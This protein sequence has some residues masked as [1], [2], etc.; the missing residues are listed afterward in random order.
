M[1]VLDVPKADAEV[2]VPVAGEGAI[3][4]RHYT[5][6]G[7]PRANLMLCHG[8]GFAIDAY[9][10]FWSPLAA[11][12]NLFAFDLRHHGRNT[13]AREW[14]I[15]FDAYADDYDQIVQ[16][17][18]QVAPGL[19]VIGALHSVS[20]ITALFHA[21]NRSFLPDALVL[22]DP[23]L[24]PPKGHPNHQYA[25]DFEHKLADWAK[26]RPTEFG[27]PS[28]LAA[29]FQKS[30]SLSGW[31]DGAHDLMARSILQPRDGGGWILRCPPE[32]EAAN[33]LAN[34]DLTTW[35]LFDRIDV[36]LAF[37][38]ADPAH[39]AGQSPAKVCQAL[40]EERGYPLIAIPETTHM[41]QIE[42]PE[43]C[44]R[45]LYRHIGELDLD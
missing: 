23:P 45:A 16:H 4:V 38:S 39:P 27:D 44:R 35:N 3:L 6:T 32:A 20:A 24:Q 19:P 10:P 12:F 40:H 2:A 43:A 29:G 37:V 11:D 31:I 15:G 34:A 22:F 25:F 36:P 28:D 8:N 17:I 13:P 9:A 18:R 42:K 26:A 1:T 14:R 30:R 33:Y 5:C 7:T 21:A 41:L